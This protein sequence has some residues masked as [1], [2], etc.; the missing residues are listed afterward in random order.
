M[1]VSK[2]SQLLEALESSISILNEDDFNFEAETDSINSS[3]SLQNQD[4][5]ESDFE[6]EF[7]KVE[8]DWERHADFGEN[9][10]QT[11]EEISL[12]HEG[13]GDLMDAE[14]KYFELV[15]RVQGWKKR[16]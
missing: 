15:K 13:S 11:M 4:A 12:D 3:F 7:L 2:N 16:K 6:N 5:L 8:Q 1:P 14:R 9:L 10:K